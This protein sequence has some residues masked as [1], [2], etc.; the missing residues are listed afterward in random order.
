M[1][2]AVMGKGKNEKG[3]ENNFRMVRIVYVFC[4]VYTAYDSVLD[5][6]WILKC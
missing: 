2:F 4:W 3:I 6:I 1:I 5:S